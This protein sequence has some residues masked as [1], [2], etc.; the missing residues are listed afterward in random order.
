MATLSYFAG[1]KLPEG[2]P[3]FHFRFVSNGLAMAPFYMIAVPDSN[4]GTV[5]ASYRYSVDY[6][7]RESVEKF[8]AFMPR[9]PEDG[10][11]APEK[12][13]RELIDRA[14]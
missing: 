11:N 3:K 8:H 2:L 14:L 6:T 12:S 7:R 5:R 10:L 13:L 1:M 9:F 4:C